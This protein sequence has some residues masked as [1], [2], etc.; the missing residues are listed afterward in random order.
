M[1][2]FKCLLLCATLVGAT[3]VASAS[4]PQIRGG[5]DLIDTAMSVHR[6][7]TF[8]MLV[9]DADLT[10]TLKDG[11]PFTVFAPTDDAFRAMP[12]G[13]LAKIHGN[14]PRLRQFVL[15]HIVRG[16][17][18]AQQ[19]VRARSMS[20]LDGGKIPSHNMKGQGMIGHARFTITNIHTSN[21]ILH[22]MDRVL[23]SK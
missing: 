1:K 22:G 12:Q 18:S 15:H 23:M 7:D 5:R 2:H 6:F 3:L 10:F 13:L 9:R 20:V 11:G 4:S 21:G 17:L 8:L 16:R 14:K 19:A